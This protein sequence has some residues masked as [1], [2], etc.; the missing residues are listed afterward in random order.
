MK[1]KFLS[2]ILTL[3]FISCGFNGKEKE[4]TASVPKF[5]NNGHELVYNMVQ[6][7]GSYDLLKTKKDVVYTYTYQTPDGKADISTEKYVFD[8]EYSYGAY[9]QHERT[10][11]ELEGLIEQGYDGSNFWL[12]HNGEY[13]ESEDQLQRVKFNRPTNFYWFTMMQKLLDDGIT[14]EYLGEKTVNNK[15]YD[16]V[17]I[18]FDFAKSKPTDIYQVYINKETGLIDQFLFTVVDFG[19]IETPYLM[20]LEYEN[21]DGILIPVNRKYK[22]STW[23]SALNNDPWIT[24]TWTNIKFNNDLKPELFKK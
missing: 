15:A 23:D 3:L 4:E 12:R 8:G 18:S 22:K 2:G 24:V 7:V 10:L 11:P 19:V 13:V 14:Y 20:L 1:I 9:M 5:Q 21:I 16:I 6:K 17:K